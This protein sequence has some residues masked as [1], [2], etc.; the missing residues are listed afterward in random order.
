MKKLLSLLLVFSLCLSSVILLASCKGKSAYEVA[1]ENGFV[2][3]EKAWLESLK[4]PAGE[5]GKAGKDGE[6]GVDG[7]EGYAGNDGFDPYQW[8][9]FN[10][11]TSK[12]T[13]QE[14][15]AELSGKDGKDGH[16]PVITVSEDGYWVID[17]V[18]TTTMV[19]GRKY[20]VTDLELVQ[21][22]FTIVLGNAAEP[23][24]SIK[25]T[26]T[27]EDGAAH[28]QKTIA[29]SKEN[30]SPAID[31]K[32]GGE[33]KVTITYAGFSKEVT[34]T[35]EAMM[36]LYQ[37]FNNLTNDSTMGQ[38]LEE[39]GFKIPV[40]GPNNT[41]DDGLT[42]LDGNPV[43]LLEIATWCEKQGED[44]SKYTL[45]GYWHGTNF[46]TLAIDNGRMC[47]TNV[48]AKE[49]F[50]PEAAVMNTEKT[51]D[52]YSASSLVIADDKYMALAGTGSYSMQAD[53]TFN[54]Q[55]YKNDS[56]WQ[57]VIFTVTNDLDYAKDNGTVEDGTPI[58]TGAAFAGPNGNVAAAVHS[59][60][61][62]SAGKG[63]D[64]LM[65][66]SGINNGGTIGNANY[67]NDVK[68]GPASKALF[69]DLFPEYTGTTWPK[70]DSG[71][72]LTVTLRIVVKDK[73][74]EDWGY[75]VY[76]KKA[77]APD[78]TFVL[79]G[80]Y[81]KATVESAKTD[82][83]DEFMDGEAYVSLLNWGTQKRNG[84]YFI[85]NVAIWTGT[86]DMP[87]NTYTGTYQSLNEAYLE[88]LP[89]D[90]AE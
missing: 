48:Q 2:G 65:M 15:I 84:G 6:A 36:I 12:K 43:K 31:F 30:V 25:Y 7:M 17:G 19:D 64:V 21:D 41:R 87:E 83:T 45:P 73:T 37:D 72:E 3:D 68:T 88:S 74:A 24:L 58:I 34:V 11:S 39:T 66:N 28:I 79:V 23:E 82:G 26:S 4:G 13:L 77:G 27:S 44:L 54:D 69:A 56:S 20:T 16:S 52:G 10:N 70:K 67:W 9:I 8:F 89:A 85:D 81:C 61:A 38:I 29:I 53:F 57:A 55:S 78:D 18:P 42:D 50:L 5:A 40:I 32:K 14:W 90:P 71:T 51:K 22:K 75:D 62:Y 80:S 33:Q 76:A 47:I 59:V 63:R 35:I 49:Y 86:G 1:V 60:Y 46:F